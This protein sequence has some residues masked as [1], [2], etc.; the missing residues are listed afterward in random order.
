M[1]HL[2]NTCNITRRWL[3]SPDRIRSKDLS[4]HHRFMGELLYPLCLNIK[5]TGPGW[6]IKGRIQQLKL[7]YSYHKELWKQ[8]QL[9]LLMSL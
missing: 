8:V 6:A 9:L 5:D 4:L 3:V 7:L 2:F 1:L